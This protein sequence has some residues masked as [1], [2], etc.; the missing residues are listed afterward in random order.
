M[1]NSIIAEGGL[2]SNSASL[3]SS[4]SDVGYNINAVIVHNHWKYIYGN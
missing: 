4:D 2:D 1:S 3:T